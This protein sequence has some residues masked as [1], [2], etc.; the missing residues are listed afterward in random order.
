[1]AAITKATI[2]NWALSEIGLPPKFS[3]DDEGAL[4]AQIDIHWPRMEARCFGL[5]DWTF[6]RRTSR[7]TRHA[8]T[9][10]NGWQ[11]GFDLPGDRIGPPLKLLSDPRRETPLRD[12]DIEGNSLFTDQRDAWARV[13]VALEPSA[14]PA[15]FTDAF[16]VALAGALAIPLLQDENMAA[17]KEMKA[18]GRPQEGGAGGM[19]GR[20]IAQDLAGKP[21]S[22][23]LLRGD[24]LTMAR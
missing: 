23:P 24:P 20:I 11:Y 18:F 17:E 2:V 3:I 6:C 21:V 13:K 9:P 12:F 5:A 8:A 1:M 4:G 16:A 15:Q 19:F 10:D 14:W 7:L 22:S